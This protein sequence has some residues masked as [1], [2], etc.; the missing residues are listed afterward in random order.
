MAVVLLLA[1]PAENRTANPLSTALL[2][3]VRGFTCGTPE[4]AARDVEAWERDRERI[5]QIYADRS[6]LDYEQAKAIMFEEKERT[7]EELLR[8]GFINSINKYNTNM[9]KETTAASTL[10]DKFE[11][12]YNRLTGRASNFI[13]TDPDGNTLFETEKE[14]ESLA[15]GDKASPDGTFTLTDGRTVTVA[16][17]EITDIAEAGSSDDLSISN[18]TLRTENEALKAENAKLSDAL[19][20]ALGEMEKLENASKQRQA[21]NFTPK[22]R[23]VQPKTAEPAKKTVDDVKA[24]VMEVRNR[25]RQNRLPLGKRK[26]KGGEA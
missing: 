24:A 2:H 18:E 8:W 6:K 5:L 3:D 4:E 26:E 13:F 10:L 21:S 20:R 14:D 19:N 1:A 15:V 12:L 23:Q 25:D 9:A 16:G 17:G 22:G 7:A 11:K